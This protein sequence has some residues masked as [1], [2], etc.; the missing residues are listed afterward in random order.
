MA[1]S[2]FCFLPLLL[3]ACRLDAL[4]V[5]KDQDP[6]PFD[7]AETLPFD[8]ATDTAPPPPE[9]ACNGVD[10]DGDGLVDEGFPDADGNG[11]VDC[12][13]GTCP[14]LDAGTAADVPIDP[15][16]EAATGGGATAR[17]DDPWNVVQQWSFVSPA[18][19]PG[20]LNA[21]SPPMVGNLTD[22]NGDG[23]VDGLD[24]PE[25]LVVLDGD[26]AWV[27]AIDGATGAEAWAYADG[28]HGATTVIA[29]VTGDS[30][31]EVITANAAGYTIVLD[32]SGS[33]VWTA[34]DAAAV[35]GY[36]EPTVADLDA[37]A[38]PEVIADNLVLDGATGAL[39]WE[40]RAF[41]NGCPY[42]HPTTGDIDAADGDQE[43]LYCGVVYDSDGTELWDTG[44]R[45][46]YGMWPFLIQA[47]ADPEAEVGFIGNRLTLWE[48]DGTNRFALDY[49]G[50]GPY[51]GPPCAGDFD[52]DGAA[53]L[54]FANF[55]NVLMY[56]LDGSAVWSVP[57]DDV[58]GLAGCS[59]FDFDGD[60]ALEV[61]YS[62]HSSLKILD[63]A[64]GVRRFET[65]EHTSSTALEY[66]TVAD[67]DGDGSAEILT[68][69]NWGA[70]PGVVAYTHGGAGWPAAGP[71]WGVYDYAMTNVADD[72][73]VPR[74]R[75]NSWE[76]Y[77]LYRAR[78]AVDGAERVPDL[79][80]SITDVCLMD[81]TYGPGI[82]AVQVWNEG[83]ADVP[84]GVLLTLYEE[85]STGTAVV[86][87]VSLPEVWAGRSL[88]GIEIPLSAGQFSQTG[89]TAR[90]DDDGAGVGTIDEWDEDDNTD[91]T[92]EGACP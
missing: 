5:T 51:P 52:G 18:A 76:K 17:V 36:Y 81:C 61:L 31:P 65:F 60:G 69:N 44:E 27:V 13:D 6:A 43:I 45:G 79:R 35:L 66:P 46:V 2:T 72:G 20:A 25:V 34:A 39:L 11:R 87:T 14:P 91:S 21:W 7:T 64:T 50:D 55:P 32:G 33:L 73:T 84:A 37:D 83:A 30:A 1:R 15:A 49:P 9:E 42:T 77:N 19:A 29:D 78:T 12:L 16:T 3:T 22:D 58:S 70:H 26:G 63:G 8:T 86:A 82:V 41:G 75:E 10:D 59:G 80:V 23:M 71:T 48:A 88:D 24:S 38:Q 56:E 92:N 68:V 74:R 54:V 90:V 85:R 4:L 47:D 28:A 40:M 89:F 62:D 67:I 57:M 53:E